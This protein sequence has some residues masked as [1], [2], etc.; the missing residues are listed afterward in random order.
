MDK[1]RLRLIQ[2]AS[3]WAALG[4]LYG[5]SALTDSHAT[6]EAYSFSAASADANG[7]LQP[8][9]GAQVLAR[10]TVGGKGL[11]KAAALKM[12]AEQRYGVVLVVPKDP[13]QK[14][15]L[16][17]TLEQVMLATEGI[18]C[19][20]SSMSIQSDAIWLATL[21]ECVV[22]CVPEWKTAGSS[23]ARA[24]LVD[25][26]G[27]I[28][29]ETELQLESPDGLVHEVN[30]L[31]AQ[32]PFAS[33]QAAKVDPESLVL[34]ERYLESDGM[35]LSVLNASGGEGSFDDLNA[36]VTDCLPALSQNLPTEGGYGMLTLV[37][38]LKQYGFEGLSE[39]RDSAPIVHGVKWSYESYPGC[40]LCGMGH[41]PAE[42]RIFDTFLDE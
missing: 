27:K 41:I 37:R 17:T 18:L 29:A 23:G 25:P 15:R 2:Y 30:A 11:P 10:E 21:T 8:V 19:H 38:S 22:S 7:V 6:D 4:L 36:I 39:H 42:K 14:N 9:G 1:T 35:D 16:G 12:R 13:E 26:D 33:E 20:L 28:V 31:F 3:A 32:E 5:C 34:L 40:Q 24:L